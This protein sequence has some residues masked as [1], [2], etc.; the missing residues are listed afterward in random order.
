MEQKTALIAGSSGLVGSELL[1][2][3]LQST[4]Y[5]AIHTLVRKPSGEQNP[6]L[7]EFIVDFD[8]LE[9]YPEVFKVDDV[10]CCLGSTIKKAGSQ[11]AFKRVDVNIVIDISKQ[12]F[13]AGVNSFSVVSSMGANPDSSV[14]Y[15]RMKGLM[16]LG[17][18]NT[19]IKSVNIF[20]PSLLL[21]KRKEFRFGERVA[22]ILIYPF[23]FLFFGPLKKFKPVKSEKV[24]FAMFESAKEAKPGINIISN[25]KIV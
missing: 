2:I 14:F 12:S 19:G 11:E 3:L 21:G 15:N 1:K 17:V 10:F 16:E 13:K 8:K 24:A 25:D 23:V 7:R 5:T 18:S 20:R 4:D 6:K 22:S 9:D